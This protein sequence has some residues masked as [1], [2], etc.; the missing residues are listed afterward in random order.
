MD[1]SKHKNRVVE[2]AKESTDKTFDLSPF[3][4]LKY[5]KWKQDHYHKNDQGYY[6]DVVLNFRVYYSEMQLLTEY[7]KQKRW[8]EDLENEGQYKEFKFGFSYPKY[9]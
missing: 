6:T 3:N 2:L 5:H 4:P 1:T 7:N 9:F 8:C